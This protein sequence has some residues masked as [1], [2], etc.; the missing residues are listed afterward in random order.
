[1]I[2]VKDVAAGDIFLWHPKGDK[3]EYHLMLEIMFSGEVEALWLALCLN[4]GKTEEVSVNTTN[5]IN[6]TRIA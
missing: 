4:D 5:S 6:W 1:M 3:P 2:G